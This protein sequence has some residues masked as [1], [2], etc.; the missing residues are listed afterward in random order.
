MAVSVPY[1]R[2]A[3]SE[4]LKSH[5]AGL[6]KYEL[7]ILS[8]AYG[9]KPA[10]GI[11][12]YEPPT[13]SIALRVGGSLAKVSTGVSASGGGAPPER[14]AGDITDFSEGSRRRLMRLIASTVRDERPIFVTLTLPDQFS[15]EIS[16][17]KRY[18][19]VFGKRFRRAFPE[20]GFVW[21][22]EF[23]ERKSGSSVGSI[24]PHY[25]L[26]IW[27]V[28]LIGFREW[29]SNAWYLV[30]GSGSSDHLAAGVQSQRIRRWGGTMRYVSK[31]I[32]KTE[33]APEGWSGRSWGVV[34][35]RQIPW[36]VEVVIELPDRVAVLATRLFRKMMHLRGKTLVYG[37][38][39]IV[40]VERILDWLEWVEDVW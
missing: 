14:V 19:D 27:G 28:D 32:A 5:R 33:V 30:V 8:E 25:H 4:Y 6:S 16:D 22:I 26:L 10:P 36:A 3:I 40:N 20:A 15:A 23:K 31:Y 1:D 21:R 11:L 24:A 18:V 13:A 34:G 12:S 37:V 17:W 35:R 39:I 7:E 38:S 2:S 9:P 29:V